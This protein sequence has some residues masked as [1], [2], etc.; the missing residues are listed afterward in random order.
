M[1]LNG[2]ANDDRSPH[3]SRGESVGAGL[4]SVSCVAH[5]AF[6]RGLCTH[7]LIAT[8]GC[9]VVLVREGALMPAAVSTDSVRLPRRRARRAVTQAI[10]LRMFEALGE[11][12][13]VKWY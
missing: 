12:E 6:T 9:A 5:G 10:A 8:C 7:V 1:E 3:A 13:I 11:R 4:V 2:C